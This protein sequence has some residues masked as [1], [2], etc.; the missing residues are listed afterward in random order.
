[1]TSGVLFSARAVADLHDRS[2][3]A[4][5]RDSESCDPESCLAAGEAF[6]DLV[7]AQHRAK[8]HLWHTE[9]RARAPLATDHEIA[10]VKRA[11]DRFNQAR[12]DLA[13]QLDATLLDRLTARGLPSPHA[14]LHSESPGL[15][16]DRLS[17][18]ALKL[19]HTRE[20]IERPTAPA[21]HRERNRDRLR[22][23]TDQRE[24]LVKC[25]DRLWQ[26]ILAGQKRFKIY[27]QLKMYNDPTLNPAIYSS[28]G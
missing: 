8:Y 5:H 9:D 12:N 7:L 25:L 4:W 6:F 17:I 10:E 24:D 26:Q 1:M 20:E 21:G 2:T 18:L 28:Q 11:I 19:Y 3:T 16:I 22:V 27:R 15:M 13:E 14:D 23:L